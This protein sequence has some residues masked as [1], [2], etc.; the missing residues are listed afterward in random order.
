M[1]ARKPY[2][3]LPK[4]FTLKRSNDLLFKFGKLFDPNASSRFY[5]SSRNTELR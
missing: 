1:I 3:F 5:Q 4:K 2:S